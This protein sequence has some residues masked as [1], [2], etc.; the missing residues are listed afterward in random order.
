MASYDLVDAISDSISFASTAAVVVWLVTS[1]QPVFKR[2]RD[3][4]R[5][6]ESP[7]GRAQLLWTSLL[8][9]T[10]WLAALY[11]YCRNLVLLWVFTGTWLESQPVNRPVYALLHLYLFGL[12]LSGFYACSITTLESARNLN[13]LNDLLMIARLRTSGYHPVEDIEAQNGSSAPDRIGLENEAA[14]VV[15]VRNTNSPP[16]GEGLRS[17]GQGSREDVATTTAR[18]IESEHPAQ[19]PT[20]STSDHPVGQS[21]TWPVESP[22]RLVDVNTV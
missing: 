19:E 8:I 17:N 12:L 10:M 22:L 9:F 15:D 20:W 4:C 5:A 7:E 14:G 2:V 21:L 1:I 16:H 6:G 13:V 3:A 11:L 18:A